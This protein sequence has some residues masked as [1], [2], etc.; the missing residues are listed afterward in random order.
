MHVIP[1]QAMCSHHVSILFLVGT[2][3]YVTHDVIWYEFQIDKIGQKAFNL[4]VAS[5]DLCL[6]TFFTLTSLRG[7][8][9]ASIKVWMYMMFMS[10]C[11]LHFSVLYGLH[12]PMRMIL[13]PVMFLSCFKPVC[14][15]L[16]NC[17]WFHSKWCDTSCFDPGCSNL[18]GP[19]CTWF[20]TKWC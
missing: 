9:Y 3:I 7:W 10:R 20:C 19:T 11:S 2:P 13:Y 15:T 16:S 14:F 5:L 4:V 6:L 12:G 8:V 17:V 1:Y 18:H